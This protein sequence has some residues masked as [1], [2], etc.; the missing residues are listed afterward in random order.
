MPCAWPVTADMKNPPH[1]PLAIDKACY[2]GDGVACVL[3]TSDRAAHDALDLIDVQYEALSAVIDLED[4]LSDRVVIHADAGT[5][6]AYTWDL[7]CE[8]TEGAVA[9]AFASAAH[10]VK[11]RYVQ[12]RLLPMFME[13]RACAAVPQ[14]FGGDLTLYS[15]TQI[16]HIL[17]IMTALTLGIPEHQMRVVA[18][19]VGGGFGGKLNVYAEELL[20]VALAR[21]HG[22]PVRWNEERSENSMATIHGPRSDP[23]H[24]ARRGRRWQGHRAA[25]PAAR[26][27]GGLPPA[28]DAGHSLA[29]RVPLRRRVRPSRG[30]RLQLHVRVHDDDADRRVPRR[31]SA[32]GH[33][34]NRARR[35][36]RWRPRSES[37]RWNCASAT[38]SARSSSPTPRSADSS[39]TAVTTSPRPRR[40]QHSWATTASA[41]EQETHNIDGST[42]RLGIGVSS[43]FEMCGLAPSRVL[44]SLNYGAGGWESATVRVLPTCK[45]QV[46]TGSSPHGQ[47]HETCWSMIVADKLGV[48]PED[49]DVLHS[50]TAISPIGLDTYGSRSL[51][52]GGVAIDM[53]CDRVIDKARKI[54]GPPTRSRAGGPRLRQWHVLRQGQPRSIHAARRDRFRCVHCARSARW[55]RTQPRGERHLRSAELLVAVRDAHLRCRGRHRNRDRL[56]SSSTSPSTTAATRSTR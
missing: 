34:R 44:A 29:R 3:A 26:R 4:A 52:V 53:A 54:A 28:R 45:V 35:W 48:P 18:P 8:S 42:K 55:P 38:T 56:R 22:V 37:I 5:N 41:P 17:K 32:G 1:Y 36:I 21:K 12:Q 25:R 30:V 19:A 49:V 47:G 15:A 40:P 20:C 9:D 46:V 13:P 51:A 43:Y 50:D 24:R 2:A 33:V 6:K 14:P 23:R 16:P 10:V 27:H 31:R 7:K 11:E 39:T